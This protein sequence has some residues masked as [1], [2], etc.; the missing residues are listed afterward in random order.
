MYIIDI[1]GE[2]IEEKFLIDFSYLNGLFLK[3]PN[4]ID[5]SLHNINNNLDKLVKNHNSNSKSLI[6]EI[7]KFK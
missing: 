5:S 3:I 6:N 4:D 7:K 2:T 1:Y